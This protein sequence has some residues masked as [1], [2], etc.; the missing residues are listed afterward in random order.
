MLEEGRFL[1]ANSTIF[2]LTAQLP[3]NNHGYRL[4]N[5]DTYRV[6]AIETL[7]DVS[8]LFKRVDKSLW[9]QESDISRPNS[10][11]DLCSI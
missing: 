6:I 2:H 1:H 10:R 5:T 4:Q 9:T 3:E 11:D 7:I 8:G